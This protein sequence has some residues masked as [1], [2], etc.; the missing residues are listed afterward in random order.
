MKSMLVLHDWD[1][2][3]EEITIKQGGV[4]FW[5]V[6]SVSGHSEP[7]FPGPV[8]GQTTA[9]GHVSPMPLSKLNGGSGIRILT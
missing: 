7:H 6:N 8:V 4:L 5:L 2:M 9:A 3:Q 1:K